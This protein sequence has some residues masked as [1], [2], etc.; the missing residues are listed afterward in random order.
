MHNVKIVCFDSNDV[1]ANSIIPIKNKSHFVTCL[2][3]LLK[4]FVLRKG[5]RTLDK[6]CV[7][8]LSE[9]LICSSISG[10][11]VLIGIL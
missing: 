3:P 1:N 8:S 6:S 10:M 7:N 4:S 11:V 2:T 9:G 5:I